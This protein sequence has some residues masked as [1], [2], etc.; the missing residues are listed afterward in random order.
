MTIATDFPLSTTF[1]TD[2]KYLFENKTIKLS[3]I[4]YESVVF[5]QA[6]Y[7]KKIWHL[8]LPIHEG[9]LTINWIYLEKS[10]NRRKNY[11]FR[12]SYL[13]KNS[14]FNSLS[15]IALQ[16]SQKIYY[17][18]VIF[19]RQVIPTNRGILGAPHIG[20]LHC[21]FQSIWTTSGPDKKVIFLNW[22]IANFA[23]FWIK[24]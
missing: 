13:K 12:N 21:E 9:F 14:Y 22:L 1:W 3:E 16:F 19:P 5:F 18:N 11:N 20:D 6:S 8:R 15:A 23:N 7:T 4:T 17:E 24:T 2:K 10:S